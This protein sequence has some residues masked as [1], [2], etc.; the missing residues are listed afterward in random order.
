MS[1]EYHNNLTYGTF[2]AKEESNFF[3]GKMLEIEDSILIDNID[4]IW[5]QKLNN[6]QFDIT[7]ESTLDS[8]YYSPSNSKQTNHTLYVDNSI[9]TNIDLTK[10]ILDIN[11]ENIFKDYLFSTLKKYRTFEGIS[12]NETINN[13][14]DV[15]IRDYIVNNVMNRYK[16]SEISLYLENVNFSHNSENLRKYNN[17]WDTSVKEEYKKYSMERI[18]SKS[19]FD[20]IR[21]TLEQQFSSKYIF[22]YYFNILFEKI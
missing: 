5:Y 3:G 21:L 22:N 19:E 10:W 4:I 18:D 1:P 2:N 9:K 8:N 11:I 15:Y 6:E 12:N 17:N 7:I 20:Q 16:F 13:D 14:I